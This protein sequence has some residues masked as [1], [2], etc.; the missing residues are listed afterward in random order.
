FTK[1]RGISGLDKSKPARLDAGC[2]VV[3][4]GQLDLIACYMAG[5][6]NV[7]A[8]QGTALTAEHARILKRYVDEVVLCFDSDT[9]G[10]NAAIRALDDLLASG[11]AI[12]VAAVPAPHDPD[13]FIKESG[14]AAFQQLIDRAQGFFD[15]YLNHLCATHDLAQDKGR[16]AVVRAIGEAVRKT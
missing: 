11:L 13:S 12:R 2:A 10:R 4:K 6:H 15:F 14:G 16:V 8:P 5:V 9:A 1:G 3:C 7:V